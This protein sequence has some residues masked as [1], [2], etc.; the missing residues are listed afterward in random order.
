MRSLKITQTFLRPSS[1]KGLPVRDHWSISG[2]KSLL[3]SR[4]AQKF[5]GYPRSSGFWDPVPFSR[6]LR[7]V[8]LPWV[9]QNWLVASKMFELALNPVCIALKELLLVRFTQW[10]GGFEQLSRFNQILN[11]LGVQYQPRS[12]LQR[13][14]HLHRCSC[15][16][17][18]LIQKRQLI[19]YSTDPTTCLVGLIS[20]LPVAFCSQRCQGCRICPGVSEHIL[21][22]C[23][24]SKC[25]LECIFCSCVSYPSR[26]RSTDQHYQNWIILWAF[27]SVNSHLQTQWTSN[28]K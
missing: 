5:G 27:K 7:L 11:Q 20:C 2:A 10:R 18:V 8:I 24:W 1:C 23:R 13:R 4:F 25:K 17:W 16:V 3:F 15:K 26:T 21:N 6:V 28:L 19:R 12:V 22:S 9:L 14:K